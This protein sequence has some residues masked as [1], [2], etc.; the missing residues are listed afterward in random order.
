MRKNSGKELPA[1]GKVYL[2]KLANVEVCLGFEQ[3]NKS[4]DM[5]NIIA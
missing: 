3:Y 4:C 2:I 1:C 5:P